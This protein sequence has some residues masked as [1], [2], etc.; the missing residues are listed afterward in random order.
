MCIGL[1][2][3]I[4]FSINILISEQQSHFDDQCFIN[5]MPRCNM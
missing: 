4:D 5:H 1:Q 3:L 2:E